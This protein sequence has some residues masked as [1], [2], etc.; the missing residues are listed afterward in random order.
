MDSTT[1]CSSSI[2]TVLRKTLKSSQN[3]ELPPQKA[4]RQRRAV[5]ILLKCNLAVVNL[6][7]TGKH[8]IAKALRALRVLPR[9]ARHLPRM[10]VDLPCSC[11]SLPKLAKSRET[12]SLE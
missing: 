4:I 3:Q 5:E 8:L 11:R 12:R 7:T 6:L 9:S 2:C 10:Q 1:I